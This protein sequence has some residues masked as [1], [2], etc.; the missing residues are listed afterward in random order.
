MCIFYGKI[1]EISTD[2]I[3]LTNKIKKNRVKNEK[4]SVLRKK[5][6][7]SSIFCLKICTVL[8]I[9]LSLQRQMEKI[10]T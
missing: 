7:F 9:I 3:I 1:L 6:N 5:T 8:K 4:N 2:A 10:V